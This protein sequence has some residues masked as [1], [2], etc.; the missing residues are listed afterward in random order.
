MACADGDAEMVE[1][2]THVEVMDVTVE[3]RDD[4]ALMTCLSEDAHSLYTFEPLT[5]IGCEGGL[6]GLNPVHPDGRDVVERSPEGYGADIVW[7]ACLELIRQFVKGRA[8][9]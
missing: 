8:T 7:R 2:C 5:G 4:A 9:E 1:Q 6:I 3:E